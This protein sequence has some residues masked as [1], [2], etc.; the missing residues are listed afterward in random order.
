MHEQDND[1][2]KKQGLR[3]LL[4]DKKGRQALVCTAVAAAG[5]LLILLSGARPEA[6]QDAAALPDEDAYN[7]RYVAELQANLASIITKIAGVGDAQVLVT[8]ETGVQYVYATEHKASG[9]RT[10]AGGQSASEKS[11]SETTFVVVDA[12]GGKAPV[13]VQ[14]IEPVVQ[15][16]V[17]VCDGGGRAEVRQA[18]TDAVTTACGIGSNRVTV[19]KKSD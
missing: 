2:Q 15:G 11:T 3:A 14:R 10:M 6:Q 19:T 16:V 4:R 8:L 18:V 9:D 7:A 5:I 1:K 13:L 12:A 17:V